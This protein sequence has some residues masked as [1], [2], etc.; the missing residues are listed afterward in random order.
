MRQRRTFNCPAAFL[1]VLTDAPGWHSCRLE[2]LTPRVP[3]GYVIP[4]SGPSRVLRPE[5]GLTKLDL[6]RYVA[7]V[8]DAFISANGDRPVSLQRFS[9][10]IDGEQFFPRIRRKG[11]PTTFGP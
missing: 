9:G 3:P 2:W 7:E 5:Q 10:N 11:R 6:A 8:G 1:E 4:I